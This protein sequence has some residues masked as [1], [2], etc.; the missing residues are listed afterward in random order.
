MLISGSILKILDNKEKIN[1]LN[2]CADMIHY[3]V[4]DG[5]FTENKTLINLENIKDITKK[6]DVHLMCFDVIKYVDLLSFINPSFITF[7]YEASDTLKNI[8]YIKSKGFKVG[9]ALNPETDVKSIFEYL[10]LIDLVLIMSVP[11]GAGGQKFID[12]SDKIDVLYKYRKDNDLNFLIE[13]DGGINEETVNKVRNA[14]IVVSGSYITDSSDYG[15]KVDSLRR[16]V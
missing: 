11:P 15:K 1:E 2:K 14:D 9:L 3:D 13:V 6:I 7:H 12:V 16:C 8:K 10:D 4:M 5:I